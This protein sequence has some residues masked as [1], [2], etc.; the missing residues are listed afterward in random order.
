MV[1]HMEMMQGYEYTTQKY[2]EELNAFIEG[3]RMLQRW[4][5]FIAP[6]V[7]KKANELYDKTLDMRIHGIH[8]CPPQNQIFRALTLTPP[9][10]IHKVKVCII[11]QDPYHT[12][13]TANGLAFGVNEG[14][15]LPPSLRNIFQELHDDIGCQIPENGDLTKWAKQGV[16]LLN[17]AL[18]VEEGKPNSHRDMGWEDVTKEIFNTCLEKLPQPIVFILWGNH[19]KEFAENINWDDYNNKLAIVSPHPSPFSASKGFFGSRPF[20]KANA[21]LTEHGSEPIDWAL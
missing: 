11:G 21:F 12:P 18:S 20:S 4:N 1:R 19:A 2:L 7:V 9:Y 3:L 14:K 10:G 15:K 5:E 16:L 17:T 13:D 6:D 8:I